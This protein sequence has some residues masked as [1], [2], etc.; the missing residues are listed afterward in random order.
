MERT[1]CIKRIAWRDSEGEAKVD[2]EK[3]SKGYDSGQVRVGRYFIKD[4]QMGVVG[5]EGWK[6]EI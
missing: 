4:S 6:A 3:K 5:A 1:L 2:A